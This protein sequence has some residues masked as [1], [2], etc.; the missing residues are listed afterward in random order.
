MA[1]Q[2]NDKRCDFPPGGD[3][4]C[5]DDLGGGEGGM[6]GGM[7]GGREGEGGCMCMRRVRY[8]RRMLNAHLKP[9]HPPTHGGLKETRF[10][11][12]PVLTHTRF[13][14]I[15]LTNGFGN[16]KYNTSTGIIIV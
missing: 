7:E 2:G 8:M 4:T 11:R 1:I 3:V 13:Q 16:S 9:T 6:E 15:S 14:F 5:A 12:Q 10:R